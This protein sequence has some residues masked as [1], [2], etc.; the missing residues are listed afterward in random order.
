MVSEYIT[1]RRPFP[2]ISR[3]MHYATNQITYLSLGVEV[4]CEIVSASTHSY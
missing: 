2:V 1:A 3:T 4:Y